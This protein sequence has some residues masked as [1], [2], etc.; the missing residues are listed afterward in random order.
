MFGL[1]SIALAVALL[2]DAPP[3]ASGTETPIA[4]ATAQQIS[5]WV[6]NYYRKP[7]PSTVPARVRR[8]S[9][10]KMLVSNRPEANQMF[11]GQIMHA[12]PGKIAEWM[13]GWKD[14][15][16]ADRNMLQHAVWISQTDQGKKWLAA[17]GQKELA[18]KKGHP[19]LTGAPM[20]LEAYHMDMLWEWFFATGDKTPVRQIVSNYN[21]LNADPGEA[22]LP[23]RTVPGA[24]RATQL[25]QTIGGV[26]VWSSSSL[27]AHHEKLLEIF[28]EIQDDP[29]LPDRSGKWLKRV[30][31]L[32]ERNSKKP[33]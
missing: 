16:E 25:R 2:A 32:A 28:K 12:N 21:M 15:P 10:L 5:Q 17:N 26:A 3:Q 13:D 27:A 11:F 14:L 18:E 22:D 1:P 19:I 33:A 7:D 9:E 8:M 31:E 30:I 20:V 24:D 29:Q 23:D 6:M 4:D